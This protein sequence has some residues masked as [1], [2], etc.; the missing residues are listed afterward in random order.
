VKTLVYCTLQRLKH[1]DNPVFHRT[2]RQVERKEWLGRDEL[3]E[4]AWERQKALV[5]QAYMHSP[6]YRGKYDAAGFHPDHLQH[7]EDFVRVPLLTRDEVRENIEGVICDN[8]SRARL[9]K[10]YT[11]GSI[12][13]P[14]MIYRDERIEAP[15]MLA[16]YSRTIARWGLKLGSKT[17]R[18]WG[19]R[20]RDV[21][22]Q[23]VKPRYWRRFL[24]NSVTL[25]AYGILTSERM[26]HFAKLLESYRPD[27]II[28]Y[29]T[30]M[31][32]F[33]RFLDDRAGAGFQSKAI[34]RTAERTHPFQK[35]LIEKA[36]RSAVYD[37]YG[38]VEVDHCAAECDRRE[39]LHINADSRTV[40]IVDDTGQP[41]HPGETGELV[42]TDLINYADPLIRYRTGDLGSLLGHTCS[43]G[44]ALPLMG[45]VVGRVYDMF[46]LPDG[47]QI[48]GGVFSTFFYDHVSEVRS[49]QVHQTH[50]DAAIVRIVPT[51]TCDREMLSARALR[52][53]SNFTSG[54]MQFDIRFVK[55]IHQAVSGK[56]RHV[57]SDVS[58]R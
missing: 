41:L 13:V 19:I 20:R 43:C 26:S 31:E 5:R 55:R 56:F 24:T 6:F 40:E 32:A 18:I 16:L 27:L 14:V 2:L 36:F 7:P 10:R 37:M 35:E 57:K 54:K 58:N 1:L 42:V 49:F 22:D 23:Y 50:R 46:I 34:W 52:A 21:T 48:F 29:V 47:S 44:R 33:A 15:A 39:G 51:L 45:S 8:A 12:G 53:F 25:D 38:S 3:A 9:V 30:A 4:L 17:A 28:G 11:S